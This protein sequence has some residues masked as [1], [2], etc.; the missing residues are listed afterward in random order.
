MLSP[1]DDLSPAA[2]DGDRIRRQR[3]GAEQRLFRHATGLGEHAVLHGIE[4][5]GAGQLRLHELGKGEVH[6]VAA[7]EQMIADRLANEADFALLLDRLDQAE[8]AG[9]AA[10]IDDETAGAR[11][12]AANFLGRVDRQPA[13]KRGLRLFEQRQVL[14]SRPPSRLDGQVP[15]DIIERSRHRQ[16]HGLVFH[17]IFIAVASHRVVPAFDHVL[18]IARGS[19]NRR[20]ALD[21]SRGAPGQQRRRPVHAG[22]AQPGLGGRHQP[23]GNASAVIA[24][25]LAERIVPAR[26]PGQ[27]YRPSRQIVR[28]GQ[29]K[30]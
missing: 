29:I 20:N 12:Q 5:G 9:A 23:A 30:K 10:D 4:P 8:V 11:L 1:A 28:T 24:G 21:I 3:F 6:V 26:I 22:V 7:Q 2:H 13:V 14:Q 17:S 16:H 27:A 15:G 19:L 25:K 18:Q